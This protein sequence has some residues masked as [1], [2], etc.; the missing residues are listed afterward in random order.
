MRGIR[1]ILLT[2]MV[3]LESCG[4]QHAETA[5]ARLGRSPCLVAIVRPGPGQSE[6]ARKIADTKLPPCLRAQVVSASAETRGS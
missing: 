4:E 3:V 1:L 6:R 5:C 2:A